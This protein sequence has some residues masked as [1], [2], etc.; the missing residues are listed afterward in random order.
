MIGDIVGVLGSLQDEIVP[1]PGGVE[2]DI[3]FVENGVPE[4]VALDFRPLD[5]RVVDVDD[6]AGEDIPVNVHDSQFCY[7]P[8][9][10][11]PVKYLVDKEQIERNGIYLEID[12]R[13]KRLEG[14]GIVVVEKCRE[15]EPRKKG[16]D[17]TIHDEERMP[18]AHKNKLLPFPEVLLEKTRSK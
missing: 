8:H 15:S 14:E 2:Y 9:V 1:I 16:H 3:P 4:W 11:I 12:K 10:I 17:H 18:V 13:N 7:E 6:I 5:V